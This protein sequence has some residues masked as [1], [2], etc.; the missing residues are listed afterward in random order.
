MSDNDA[1]SFWERGGYGLSAVR[2]YDGVMAMN[3]MTGCVNHKKEAMI[4]RGR[5]NISLCGRKSN[6]L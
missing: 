2:G 3:D 1:V 4:Q 5:V 6:I